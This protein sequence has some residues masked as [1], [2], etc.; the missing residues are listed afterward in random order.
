MAVQTIVTEAG[1][2]LVVIPEQ[3]YR[4][5]VEAADDAADLEAVQKFHAALATGEEE[6]LPIELVDRILNGESRIRVWREHRGMT[7]K[8][9]AETAGIAPAYLSQMETGRR[10]G[11]VETLRKV[12]AG[13]GVGLDEIAG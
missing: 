11:T 9:L 13:L 3:E 6:L 8:A 12:A 4:A 5:L 7:V 2:K 10:A 1:E